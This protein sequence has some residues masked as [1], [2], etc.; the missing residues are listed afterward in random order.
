MGEG[1][2]PT[3]VPS[4]QYYKQPLGAANTVPVSHQPGFAFTSSDFW[5]QGLNFGLELRY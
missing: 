5:A 3:Q 4:S 1:I 2:D